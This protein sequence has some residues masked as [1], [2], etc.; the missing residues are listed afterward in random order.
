M[1]IRCTEKT[2]LQH[3]GLENTMFIFFAKEVGK[4]TNLNAERGSGESPKRV[5]TDSITF[6][7][8][9]NLFAKPVSVAIPTARN[10]VQNNNVNIT[11][12]KLNSWF[13]CTKDSPR[14]MKMMA[15][16]EELSS[17]RKYLI[18][19]WDFLDTLD[20]T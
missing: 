15:S 1:D 8:L 18:V 13:S 14:N 3:Q 12:A 4:R 19:V 16:Q 6:S 11:K 10:T 2:M 5:E 9:P 20:S 7:N 17:L